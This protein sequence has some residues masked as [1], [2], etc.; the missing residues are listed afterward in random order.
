[1]KEKAVHSTQMRN[2]TI[3]TT[4]VYTCIYIMYMY[5]CVADIRVVT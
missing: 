5:V 1:M 2:Y 4:D 3:T